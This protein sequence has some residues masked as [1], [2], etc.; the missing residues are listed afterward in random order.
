MRIKLEN[1]VK[2]KEKYRPIIYRRL[3][4]HGLTEDGLD[5]KLQAIQNTKNDLESTEE[6]ISTFQNALQEL[7]DKKS[8]K[9]QGRVQRLKGWVMTKLNE[10]RKDKTEDHVDR[11]EIVID[12]LIDSIPGFGGVLRE[13]K[14][15]IKS[16][17][18]RRKLGEYDTRKAGNST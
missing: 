16:I 17:F 13:A 15:F 1:Q 12:S 9:K 4:K 6:I 3:K 10:L 7:E 2:G 5:L 14:D 18:F 8:E 11:I